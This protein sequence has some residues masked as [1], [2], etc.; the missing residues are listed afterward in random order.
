MRNSI[1]ADNQ[2]FAIYQLIN[3]R[4]N[5]PQKKAKYK[6]LTDNSFNTSPKFQ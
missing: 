3:Y 5:E 1:L 4:T 6:D 2:K